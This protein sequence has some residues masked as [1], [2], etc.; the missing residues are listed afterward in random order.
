M[1]TWSCFQGFITI[2]SS[3]FQ[4]TSIV[5][6]KSNREILTSHGPPFHQLSLWNEDLEKCADIK[7]HNGRILK[8]VRSPCGSLV[9]SLSAD[10]TL[11]VW[12][13]FDV[14]PETSQSGIESFHGSM[15]R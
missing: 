2:H 6:S 9:A 5:W 13:C 7:G 14:L 12:K 8:I 11:R 4:V 10:E 3:L 1:N 15:I